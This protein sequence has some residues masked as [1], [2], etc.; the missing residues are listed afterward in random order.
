MADT[1]SKKQLQK[2]KAKKKSDKADKMEQRKTNNNKGKSLDSMIVY[3]DENGFFSDTP[4]V[5]TEDK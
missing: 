1:F 5:K 4:P 2:K 3:I